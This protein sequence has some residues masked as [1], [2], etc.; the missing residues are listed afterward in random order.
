M[1]QGKIRYPTRMA[2][3]FHNFHKKLIL[4]IYIYIFLE[5]KYIENFTYVDPIQI[6]SQWEERS[7]SV[8][9][10]RT[11]CTKT[12]NFR[13]MVPQPPHIIIS[14]SNWCIKCLWTKNRAHAPE[15]DILPLYHYT[16]SVDLIAVE[17]RTTFLQNFCILF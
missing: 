10:I 15:Y 2:L 9:Y 13:S 6:R 8:Y 12:S 16:I 5:K 17:R 4:S 7:R 1:I 3:I 11:F 14:F